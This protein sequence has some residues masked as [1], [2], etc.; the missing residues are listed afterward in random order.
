MADL[1]PKECAAIAAKLTPNAREVLRRWACRKPGGTSTRL[2]MRIDNKPSVSYVVDDVVDCDP[3]TVRVLTSRGLAEPRV[4][5]LCL[6]DTGAQV[7]RWLA[8]D[9]A[10]P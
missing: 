10:T 8:G 7:A 2:G 9:K 6:K 1:T 3:R 5:W 4:L